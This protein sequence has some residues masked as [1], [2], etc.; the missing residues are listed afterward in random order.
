MEEFQKIIVKLLKANMDQQQKF[1]ETQQKLVME[2]D[3][4]QLEFQQFTLQKTEL[5]QKLFEELLVNSLN[6][7]KNSGKDTI[8][9]QSTIYYRNIRIRTREPQNVRGFLQAL[10]KYFQRRLWTKAK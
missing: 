5:Q 4:R 8:Y 7:S 10:W 1:K 9:S 3:K 6:G 2:L